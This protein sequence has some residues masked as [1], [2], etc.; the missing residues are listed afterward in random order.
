MVLLRSLLQVR[1]ASSDLPPRG[2][3][4]AG[5]GRESGPDGCRVECWSGSRQAVPSGGSY[6]VGR[7][8]RRLRCGARSCGPSPNSLRSLRSATFKQAATSQ[9]T[10]RASARAA[11][12]VLLAAPEIAP[13]GYRLPRA[14]PVVALDTKRPNRRAKSMQAARSPVLV[15]DEPKLQRRR[16]R[17]GG[18][19]PLRQRGGERGRKQSSGLFSPSERPATGRRGLQ[20]HGFWQRACALRRL[21]RGR[22]LSASPKGREASS[23][24]RPR[25]EHRSAVAVPRDRRSEALT[26]ARM[27]LCRSNRSAVYDFS[28]SSTSNASPH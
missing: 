28:D 17:A 10:L 23:A 25:A 2:L 6:G 11:C 14:E 24:A 20:G 4:R 22:C 15:G 5:S 18:G 21:T 8:V 16:V 12:P 19:A 26:P 7:R 3:L 9:F 1:E 13:A 27:R